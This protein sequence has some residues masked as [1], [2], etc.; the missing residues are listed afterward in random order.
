M[1][2]KL[3]KD[4]IDSIMQ[5]WKEEVLKSDI[6]QKNKVII[7]EYTDIR[8]KFIEN[9]SS[10]IVY[11]E[12]GIIEGFISLDENCNIWKILVK[13]EIRREG[14]GKILIESIKKENIK[15]TVNIEEKDKILNKFFTKMGFK[16]ESESI[17]TQKSK[18]DI[19]Y[20]W[21]K[22][23]LKI[24]SVIYFDNDIDVSLINPNS[25]IEYNSIK[26]KS[27]LKS[28]NQQKDDI[29]IYLK[30]RRKIEEVVNNDKIL[31]YIDY[32]NYYN[33]LDEIIK[34]I[35]KIKKVNLDIVICEPFTIENSKKIEN[36]K[37][38]EESFK[39]YKI[40]KIDFSTDM[41]KNININ[42][43]SNRKSE[44]LIQKIELLA[45]NM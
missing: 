29:R 35:V 2:K 26:V 4:D 31:L 9:I 45:E 42:Q 38:I 21:N 39:D 22:E 27:Y 13:K 34:E 5:F 6:T 3:K 32:N 14:I 25:K 23:P 41:D 20:V 19:C 24:A 16:K 37:A 44:I 17:K 1:L 10:T 12:D 33:L 28:E 43:I 40:H 7:D 18:K 15:L 30:I 8:K 11:T 36:I